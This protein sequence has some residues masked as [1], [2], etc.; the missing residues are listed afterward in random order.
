VSA[1]V[2]ARGKQRYASG[3]CEISLLVGEVERFPRCTGAGRSGSLGW[4]M[5]APWEAIDRISRWKHHEPE[6]SFRAMV[7]VALEPGLGRGRARWRGKTFAS[8]L[9]ARDAEAQGTKTPG[10]PV[11]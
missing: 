7:L 3:F 1:P 9:F 8:E 5:A 11:G 4:P 10:V 6:E 2:D